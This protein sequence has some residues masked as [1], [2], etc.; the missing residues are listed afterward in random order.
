MLPSLE[1]LYETLIIFVK[2]A[3]T[4]CAKY[5]VWGFREQLLD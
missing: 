5:I 3:A 2:L 4:N 1:R